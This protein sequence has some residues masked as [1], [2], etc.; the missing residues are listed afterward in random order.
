MTVA[1]DGLGQSQLD[2]GGIHDWI[3]GNRR[4]AADALPWWWVGNRPGRRCA[5]YLV[6]QWKRERVMEA[7]I[8]RS[9]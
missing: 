1:I 3:L 4:P 7:P 6:N 5:A 2:T 9:E 8:G